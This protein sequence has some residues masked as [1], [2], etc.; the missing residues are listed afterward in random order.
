MDSW[1]HVLDD[2]CVRELVDKYDF[3]LRQEALAHFVTPSQLKTVRDVAS[4]LRDHFVDFVRQSDKLDNGTLVGKL[5]R[6]E[7]VLGLGEV[8]MIGRG[9]PSPKFDWTIVYEDV[10]DDMSGEDRVGPIFTKIGQL[11]Q[12]KTVDWTKSTCMRNT[13]LLS[14]ETCYDRRYNV[15]IV[16]VAAIAGLK[17]NC[18]PALL[19]ALAHILGKPFARATLEHHRASENNPPASM[20]SAHISTGHCLVKE[21]CKQQSIEQHCYDHG[22]DHVEHLSDEMT[23]SSLG[24]RLAHE[25]LAS[26]LTDTRTEASGRWTEKQEF[27]VSL[28]S[29]ALQRWASHMVLSYHR[30][31]EEPEDRGEYNITSSI[32]GIKPRP[33]SVNDAYGAQVDVALTQQVAFVKAFECP[34]STMVGRASQCESSL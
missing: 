15:M 25:R 17:F 28:A 10:T 1:S 9:E 26:G 29:E 16:P 33:F 4:E 12:E 30:V 31:R 14:H 23:A 32:A 20:E 21:F 34:R 6:L 7:V 2:Q 18:K 5:K 27:W 22:S 24:Y 11:L 13:S 19:G 8:V 3:V